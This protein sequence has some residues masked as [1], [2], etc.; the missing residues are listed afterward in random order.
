MKKWK[1]VYRVDINEIDEPYPNDYN[2]AVSD[3]EEEQDAGMIPNNVGLSARRRES[4]ILENS[5]D[6]NQ[7]HLKT[8]TNDFTGAHNMK[9][10][11]FEE[12]LLQQS[13]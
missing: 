9:E 7:S 13:S 5:G 4:E 3:V 2:E 8:D 6:P 1:N 12:L 10:V 11:S